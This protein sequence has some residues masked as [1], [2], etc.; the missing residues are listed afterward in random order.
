MKIVS[1]VREQLSAEVVGR[2][3]K[4]VGWIL[5]MPVR[6]GV[7]LERNAKQLEG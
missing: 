4:K 1:I 7:G 5:I 3:S 2:I 6:T